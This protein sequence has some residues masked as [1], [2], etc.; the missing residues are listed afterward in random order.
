M[1]ERDLKLNSLDRYAKTSP[2]FALEQYGSCEVPAGCGGVVLRWTPRADA[3]VSVQISIVAPGDHECLVD[4]HQH[5]SFERLR[6][7]RHVLALRLEPVDLKSGLFIG[8]ISGRGVDAR[9]RPDG[10]WRYRLDEPPENW[11][12]VGYDASDWTPLVRLDVPH[13]ARHPEGQPMDRDAFLN[14]LYHDER[15]AGSEPLGLTTEHRGLPLRPVWVRHEFEVS[16]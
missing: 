16:L 4:G 14:D 1:S 13:R 2:N 15:D 5:T 8:S 10:T 7:G 3:L 6:Q 11:T 9:T 12:A